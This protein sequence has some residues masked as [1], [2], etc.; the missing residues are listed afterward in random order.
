MDER[1]GQPS[2]AVLEKFCEHAQV[3]FN[4]TGY[5]R[6]A[7]ISVSHLYN[8]RASKTYQRQRCMLIKTIPKKAPIGQRG[9][10]QQADNPGIF[11]ST[12]YTKGIR[13]SA[14]AKIGLMLQYMIS[15]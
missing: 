14:K 11:A 4:S 3:N 6:L 12:L 10:P 5:T 13:T 1:H 8:L 7:K 9:K 2:G 15:F